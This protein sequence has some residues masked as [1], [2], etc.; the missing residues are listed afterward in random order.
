MH[1]YQARLQV[2][3]SAE[4]IRLKAAREQED[5]AAAAAAAQKQEALER[6]TSQAEAAKEEAHEEAQV[7][8]TP[9]LIPHRTSP[10]LYLPLSLLT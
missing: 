9:H 4:N 3:L 7:G 1:V 8:L 6:V 10:H 5:V 2:E